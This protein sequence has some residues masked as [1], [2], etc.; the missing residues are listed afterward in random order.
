MMTPDGVRTLEFGL[1]IDRERF[2]SAKAGTSIAV[3]IPCHNEASTI[4][5]LAHVI[6]TELLA[7]GLIDEFVV[8][9][10]QS[11]DESARLASDAGATVVP[12]E[13]INKRFGQGRGKGNVLWGSLHVTTSDITVWCDAD[14]TSFTTD[15]VLAL[16]LPLLED[17]GLNLIKAFYDR[18]EDD[19]GGGR[20]TELV[21]RPV[22][23]LYFSE[24]AAVR[25]PL[26][27]EYALRR[28]AAVQ[29]PFSQGWGVEIAMLI[30]VAELFS[31][32]SIGQVDL[33]VRRHRHRPLRQLAVQ[34]AEVMAT[35][36]SRSPAGKPLTSLDELLLQTADG[37]SVAVNVSE[38][39]PLD[40]FDS[41]VG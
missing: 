32:S 7:P 24:L 4:G 10:D 30:D 5:A 8:I 3:C 2:R 27:G 19:G 1:P 23:S 38:R 9:D 22:L 37:S 26:A 31:V 25:Q 15:W 40:S 39:P 41:G 17:D 6:T 14:V 21:A 33:G 29:I 28:S 16:A 20:T 13:T 12:I 18:P 34:A 11:T 36:L 35:A